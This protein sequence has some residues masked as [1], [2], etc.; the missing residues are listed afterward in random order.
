[1]AAEAASGEGEES[2][3]ARR[4]RD[5]EEEEEAAPPPPP[6]P[7]TSAP[8]YSR[9]PRLGLAAALLVALLAAKYYRDVETARRQVAAFRAPAAVA[10]GWGPRPL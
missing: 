5:E 2:E 6:P 1:M 8:R 9:L 4:P 10:G 3:A 7:T